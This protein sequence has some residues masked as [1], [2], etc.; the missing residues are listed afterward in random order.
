MEITKKTVGNLF[1]IFLSLILN[2]LEMMNSAS[3][4]NTSKTLSSVSLTGLTDGMK[5]VMI[6]R[7]FYLSLG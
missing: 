5:E 4:G 3:K 2:Y 7:Y 6:S 1:H